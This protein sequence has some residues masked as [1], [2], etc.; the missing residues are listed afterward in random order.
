[1]SSLRSYKKLGKICSYTLNTISF[2]DIYYCGSKKLVS[3]DQRAHAEH[4]VNIGRTK[5]INEGRLTD[6]E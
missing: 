1:M 3:I 4:V 2:L 5:M 6:L